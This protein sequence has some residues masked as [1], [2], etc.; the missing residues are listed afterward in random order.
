MISKSLS[1]RSKLLKS[2]VVKY[3]TLARS[4]NPPR[5]ELTTRDVMEMTKAAD[6]R[7]LCES[8]HDILAQKWAR[9]EIREA[10]NHALRVDHA[11][12]E[13]IR[14]QV[15]A[16]RLQTWMRDELHHLNR[17]LEHLKSKAPLLAHVLQLQVTYQTHVNSRIMDSIRC[18]ESHQYF[19]GRSGCGI[20]QEGADSTGF[21]PYI[22]GTQNN[23]GNDGN[24][25]RN[26]D[27]FNDDDDSDGDVDDEMVNLADGYDRI[28]AAS[29]T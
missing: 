2:A 11:R 15:E 7:L 6:F 10:T 20:R 13:L 23:A 25:G 16:R 27:S 29:C 26:D 1:V 21:T 19:H 4:A 28:V 18:I 17:T 3:N 5:L 9:P 12:E 14:I 24:Q 22:P 8:R